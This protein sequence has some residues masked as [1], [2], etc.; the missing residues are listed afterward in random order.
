VNHNVYGGG[1]Y[2]DTNTENWSEYEE[3]TGL[4]VG[5]TSV[6][7]YYEQSFGGIFSTTKDTVAKENK[8]YYRKTTETWADSEKKSSLNKTRLNLRGGTIVGDAYGGALGDATHSPKVY[9]DIQVDLN[10]ETCTDGTTVTTKTSSEV[11]CVEK[12]L[13]GCIN[14]YGSPQGNV[15]VHV[16]GTQNK[17]TSKGTI[18]EKFVKDDINLSSVSDVST[19]KAYLADQIKVA[20]AISVTTTTYEETYNNGS[21]T[22]EAVKTA[23][24]GITSAIATALGTGTDEEKETKQATA[25]ALRYD[26]RAVYG[27]G[28][29]AA[30]DPVTPN[31]ST[32][33][34]PNGPRTLVIIEGCDLTSI[35]HVYGGGNAAPV[36]ATDVTIKGTYLINAVY[37]GGNGSGEGNPGADVGIINPTAYAANHANGTYGTGKA[38]TKLLG[39]Y[40]NSVYGGSNTKG[41]VVGGTDVST[42]KQ[43][44]VIDGNCCSELKVGT[45]YGA[46]SHADVS[47]DVNII[48]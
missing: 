5:E 36:P 22:E 41:D 40:I 14:A 43:G 48:L 29:E 47:G 42:K 31:T 15:T 11:G 30:Y 35:D 34:T 33:T 9:G 6:T 26:V 19:L 28:N 44:D 12:Q 38:V 24:T 27:G 17:D 4:T 39:G 20:K 18:S 46:G 32:T 23:I 2:A 8:K 7:G 21:A 45:V 25:N 3:V 37:G 16:Y 1:A 10:K 13:F